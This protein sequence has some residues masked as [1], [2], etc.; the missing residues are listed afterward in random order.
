MM[1]L[2]KTRTF[3]VS[4]TARGRGRKLEIFLACS[5]GLTIRELIRARRSVVQ[6]P[7]GAVCRGAAQQVVL[8]RAM[9]SFRAHDPAL[10]RAPP[11]NRSG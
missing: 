6:L 10:Q 9:D 2:E 11:G 7:S 8:Q 5:L 1:H 4:T 3:R